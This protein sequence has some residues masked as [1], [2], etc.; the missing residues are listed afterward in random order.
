M[1]TNWRVYGKDTVACKLNK[2]D[3]PGFFRKQVVVGPHEGAIVVRNGKAEETITEARIKVAGVLDGIARLFGGGADID[4]FFADLGPIDFSIYLG[5]TTKATV[6]GDQRVAARAAVQ[7][8]GQR[9]DLITASRDIGWLEQAETTAEVAAT[10][11]VTRDVSEVSIVATSLDQEVITAECLLRVR[12]DASEVQ[13]FVGLVKGKVALSRWDLAALVRDELLARVLIPEIAAHRADELRGNRQLLQK[14]EQDVTAQLQRTFVTCGMTLESFTLNWGLTEQEMAEID[15]KRQQR[16]E[17]ALAFTHTRQLAHMQ[18][19]LEVERTRLDNL[20]QLKMA[21][22]QGNEELQ[23]LF[24]AGGIRRELMAEGKKVDVA[25]IDAQI[26]D[27]EIDVD[28]RES[29]FRLQKIR[30]HEN[31]RLDI[32][33]RQFKVKQAAREAEAA[34]EEKDMAG[35]VRMQ[36]QM[37]TAKHEREMAQRRQEIEAD[38]RKRQAEIEDRY[39]QRKLKLDEDLARMGMMERLVSQGIS[40]G[41]GESG[42]LKTM[43]EQ[44]TEQAYVTAS[45]DKVRSRS[46]AAAAKGSL[47]TYQKAEDREREHQKETTK[48]AT[49]MMQASKQTPASTVISGPGGLPAAA[50][51]PSINVVNVPPAPATPQPPPPPLAKCAACGEAIQGG[52][53]VCPACGAAVKP[54]ALCPACGKPVQAGWK[55]CPECGKSLTG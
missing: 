42:V 22:A 40:T 10:Q 21:Q 39:Q 41:A 36:I 9:I 53:K 34:L 23:D 50:Q 5:R 55:A 52:W 51:P 15:R 1:A 32:E 28:R 25:R 7:G 29:Q 43:L 14:I 19:Q 37:A 16:E 13:N 54:P 26:R 30:D 38:F 6:S 12:V 4:I 33:D 8:S 49:E 27:I 47:E 48:L 31:L 45:D 24:L 11:A 17:E 35:M 3:L 18:R 44:A 20:Q 2:A 46:Q